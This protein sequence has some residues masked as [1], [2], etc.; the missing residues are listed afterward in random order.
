LEDLKKYLIT[1]RHEQFAHALVSKMLTFA[2]GRSLE[3]KDEPVIRK[4]NEEF[5]QADY[6]LSA[7]M[8]NIIQ[9]KPFL[10][11]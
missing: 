2:L 4:L 10:S 6:R 5:M 8:K 3:L 7:L 11:R 9:S 1:Q